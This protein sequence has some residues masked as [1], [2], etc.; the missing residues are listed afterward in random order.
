MEVPILYNENLIRRIR[1]PAR[2]LLR[3]R[4]NGV[5]GISFVHEPFVLVRDS[6][7]IRGLINANCLSKAPSN[8]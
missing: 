5:R 4:L 8:M 2:Q 3:V 6:S 1:G 7:K